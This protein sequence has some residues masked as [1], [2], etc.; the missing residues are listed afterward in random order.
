MMMNSQKITM[1]RI[2]N[3]KKFYQICEDNNLTDYIFA[4]SPLG[5]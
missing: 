4:E 3:I 1:F 5:A 2:D